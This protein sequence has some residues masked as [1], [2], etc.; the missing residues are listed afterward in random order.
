MGRYDSFAGGLARGL[1]NAQ[2]RALQREEQERL[3]KIAK[4]EGQLTEQK[5]KEQNRIAES[6]QFINEQLNMNQR[7]GDPSRTPIFQDFPQTPGSTLDA[8][9]QTGRYQPPKEQSLLD[10][11]SQSQAFAAIPEFKDLLDIQSK[12]ASRDQMKNLMGQYGPSGGQNG[13]TMSSVTMDAD[14]NPKITL[15]PQ[16]YAYTEQETRIIDGRQTLVNVTYD[17]Q[18]RE[19]SVTP[20][21]GTVEIEGPGGGTERVITQGGR[22][23]LNGRTGDS[24]MPRVE[25]G[26]LQLK[27]SERDKYPPINELPDFLG[28][29]GNAVP[30]NDPKFRR[31]TRE[32]LA[33][34]GYI[35]ANPEV[36][37]A[38]NN[39][40]LIL[41]QVTQLNGLWQNIDFVQERQTL[42]DKANFAMPT[43]KE[44][45]VFDQASEQHVI[46]AS[47]DEDP[48][49][50]AWWDQVNRRLDVVFNT[51][52]AL[53]EYFD[54]YL[55]AAVSI[56]RATGEV[57]TMTEGD[58][59]RAM[60]RLPNPGIPI[61]DA[62]N[63][64][65]FSALQPD[66]NQQAQRK[67]GRLTELVNN[68][69]PLKRWK[70]MFGSGAT[71]SD[72]TKM[73]DAEL[74]ALAKERG[75]K[76]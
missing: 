12:Q 51:N 50:T 5:L 16:R 61:D 7:L 19:M 38:F 43:A 67:L 2:Q 39:R 59:A 22:P 70:K 48:F 11:L 44:F 55:T 56:A 37:K 40:D 30:Q 42:P 46:V 1:A 14:G 64:N 49:R 53:R 66:N 76:L 74:Q 71:E 24:N 4:L 45:G 27:R 65:L 31:M 15:T 18:G 32:Q 72:Y 68:Q 9:I 28:P 36:V 41:N 23:V 57:G 35:K 34:S 60:R 63:I 17:R 47:K 25:G 62:G 52:P 13:M 73:S 58:V 21:A 8:A 3:D 33:N 54:A 10:I 75:I 29:D 69:G 26:G 20:V 6:R